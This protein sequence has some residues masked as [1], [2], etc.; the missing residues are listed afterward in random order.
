MWKKTCAPHTNMTTVSRKGM[1]LQASSR[2][3]EPSISS[4]RSSS[5]RRRY[6]TAKTT[7]VAAIPTEKNTVTP[8]RKRKR[9]STSLAMTEACSGK[10]GKPALM[11]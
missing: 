5:E 11:A 6:L 3:S 9:A 7:S 4:G 10:R 1:M 8:T 2:G